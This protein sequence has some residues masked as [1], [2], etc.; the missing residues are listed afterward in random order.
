MKLSIIIPVHNV[1]KYISKTIISLV[2]QTEKQFEVII[3]DDG[4]T[5]KT[6]S[7]AENMLKFSCISNYKIIRKENGGVSS[8]RN[9]GIDRSSGKYIMFLDGDDYV[10]E[11]LVENI[12][13]YL[14]KKD[15]DILSWG[16]NKVTEDGKIIS[17][18]SD[19]YN[20]NLSEMTGIEALQRIICENSLWICMG[21]AVYNKQLLEKH[22]FR[23]E[24][25]CTSGEDIEFTY[26]VLSKA[27][28]VLFIDEIL[29]Y[30]LQRKESRSNT[31]DINKLDAIYAIERAFKYIS[32]SSNKELYQISQFM[33][34]DERIKVYLNFLQSTFLNYDIAN[35]KQIFK[36]IENVFPN[37]NKEMKEI[38]KNYKGNNIKLVFKINF[39]LLS[40]RLY[41]YFFKF[42]NINFGGAK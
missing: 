31:Y 9:Y 38:M 26:K 17:S 8:A 21:S 11:E 19:K 2:N 35:F 30:Y 13:K 24:N 27:Q 41:L 15:Y 33:K 7:I 10:S 37:S 3:I 23:F 22:M 40:P 5:D 28:R 25:K 34:Y 6:Y 29:F 16:F 32:N 12:Y 14:D 4:S 18:Y 20:Y 36:S 1:E 42:K 39:F